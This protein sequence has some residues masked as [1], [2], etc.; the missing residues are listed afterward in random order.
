[1]D[2]IGIGPLPDPRVES[3]DICSRLIRSDGA[4]ETGNRG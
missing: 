3:K 2:G 1:M 4:D